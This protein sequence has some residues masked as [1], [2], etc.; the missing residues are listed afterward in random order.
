MVFSYYAKYYNLF[1]N[2]SFKL[3]DA[4]SFIID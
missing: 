1:P 2:A 4:T 3:G